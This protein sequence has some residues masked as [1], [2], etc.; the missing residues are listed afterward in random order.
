M[1]L[2]SGID[3]PLN[4]AFSSMHNLAEGRG[5]FDLHPKIRALG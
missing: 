3:S 2:L 1:V 4:D 5:P